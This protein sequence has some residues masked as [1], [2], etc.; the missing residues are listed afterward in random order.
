M[1]IT[2]L[3]HCRKEGISE[4][5]KMAALSRKRTLSPPTFFMVDGNLFDV[6]GQI[7]SRRSAV[8]CYQ[9]SASFLQHP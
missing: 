8:L 2:Y 1:D 6:R 9:G 4:K 3:V 5:S 7:K